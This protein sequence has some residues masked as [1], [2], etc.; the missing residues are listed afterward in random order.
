MYRMVQPRERLLT[1]TVEYVAGQG[2]GDVSLRQL[3]A[4]IG[5]SHRMLIYHFGSKEA[6]LVE[7]V[8][9]VEQAQ[10]DGLAE[11]TASLGD[12]ATPLDVMRGLWARVTDEAM[13]PYERLFFEVYGRALQ[14]DPSFA[15]LLDGVVEAWLP[16][17]AELNERAGFAPADAVAHARLQLAVT[18]GLLL[19]LLAIGDRD[20]VAA[21]ADRFAAML[22]R[23]M[24]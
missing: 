7:V 16:Q 1:A 8:R 23:E 5:T 19:D 4:A 14:G 13:A 22:E 20:A 17:L 12:G 11:L 15:P 10:R 2:V 6:L 21:A 24:P 18:R 3:A 9:R